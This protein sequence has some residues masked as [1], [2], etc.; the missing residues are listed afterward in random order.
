VLADDD[1]SDHLETNK[2]HGWPGNSK[3]ER[4]TAGFGLKYET[5]P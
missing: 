2:G 5:I 3:N 4:T 1:L